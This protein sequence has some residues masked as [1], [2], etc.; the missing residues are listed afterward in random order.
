MALGFVKQFLRCSPILG[1]QIVEETQ[2]S[3][4]LVGGCVITAVPC[5]ARSSRGRANALVILDEAA[6][7]V[8]S[9]GNQSMPAL[10]DALTPHLRSS[11]RS[12]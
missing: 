3:I 7:M 10:L 12:D 1:E 4:T 6:H 9:L 8:D 11:H 2:S 5:S